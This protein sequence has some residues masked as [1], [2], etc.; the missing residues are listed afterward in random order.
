[1]KA[2]EE[3][4]KAVEFVKTFGIEAAQDLWVGAFDLYNNNIQILNGMVCSFSD[5]KFL[6][7]L[8]YIKCIIESHELVEKYKNKHGGIRFRIRWGMYRYGDTQQF[9]NRLKQAI[10]DVESCQ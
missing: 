2:N 1:M 8:I 3:Y 5:N 4:S 6:F 10:A 9:N 7:N